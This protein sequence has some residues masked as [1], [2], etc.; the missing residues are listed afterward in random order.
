MTSSAIKLNIKNILNKNNIIIN[1]YYFWEDR[2]LCVIE[3]KFSY[4]E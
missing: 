4:N 3:G 2:N 1:K